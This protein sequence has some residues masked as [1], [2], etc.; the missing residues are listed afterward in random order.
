MFM[1]EIFKEARD[2]RTSQLKDR[3]QHKFSIRNTI[4]TGS[5][6]RLYWKC[7]INVCEYVKH[8]HILYLTLFLDKSAS[9]SLT[10][11][12]YLYDVISSDDFFK[13]SKLVG[14]VCGFSVR[15]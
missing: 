4:Q 1:L 13:S 6:L 5:I 15:L 9:F 14:L 8:L 10:F 7:G 2:S 11:I 12:S 3:C